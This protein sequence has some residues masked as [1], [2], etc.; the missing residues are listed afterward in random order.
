MAEVADTEI[1]RIP[2]EEWEAGEAHI[3]GGPGDDE[4]I[5]T[6]FEDFLDAGP[7]LDSVEARGGDDSL[8]V[9]DGESPDVASGGK[10]VD[11]CLSDP[12]DTV[13]GCP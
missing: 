8:D 10:G 7:G 9:Q 1:S 6:F 4:L 13:T 3:D 11:E 2:P 5:G 12:G